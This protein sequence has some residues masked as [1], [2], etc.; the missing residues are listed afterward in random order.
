MGTTRMIRG[1]KHMTYKEKL[2]VQD[3]SSFK[4][5]RLK[6]D[7][8]YPMTRYRENGAQTLL[9][10][11]GATDPAWNMKSFSQIKIHLF[12]HKGGKTVEQEHF[13]Y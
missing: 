12:Q 3:L 2:R 7:F 10:G 8:N 6:G 13:F 1:L 9:G 5:R 4:K 11:Q